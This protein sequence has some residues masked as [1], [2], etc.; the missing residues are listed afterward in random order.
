MRE[1]STRFDGAKQAWEQ[2]GQPYADQLEATRGQVAQ[3]VAELEQGQKD[4]E[5]FLAEHPD[6]PRRLA[7]L[8]R[9][10]EHEQEFRRRHSYQRILQREQ[11]RH[12]AISHEVDSGLGID[13]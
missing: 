5:A 9:A 1:G 13:L 7:D 10:I 2:L 4:R 3:R 12:L 8:D 6:V 11:V